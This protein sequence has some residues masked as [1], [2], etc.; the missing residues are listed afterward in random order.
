MQYPIDPMTYGESPDTDAKHTLEY[1][2]LL[3]AER[4]GLQLD[5]DCQYEISTIV[6]NIIKEAVAQAIEKGSA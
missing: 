6:D 1:Y 4:A 2:F 3:I 5:K